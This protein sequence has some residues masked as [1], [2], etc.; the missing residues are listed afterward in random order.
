MGRRDKKVSGPLS[1][2][3]GASKGLYARG[4][5]PEGVATARTLLSLLGIAVCV[6]GL[7]VAWRLDQIAGMALLVVG[8][9]LLI[10]PFTAATDEE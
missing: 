10:L 5:L 9:F 8:G 1:P 6:V 2:L 4:D 7:L 3:A